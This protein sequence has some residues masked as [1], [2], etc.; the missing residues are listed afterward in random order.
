MESFRRELLNF[1]EDPT[2]RLSLLKNREHESLASCVYPESYLKRINELLEKNRCENEDWALNSIIKL[3]VRARINFSKESV[4]EN[5]SD[6][7][8][9]NKSMR[10]LCEAVVGY[11]LYLAELSEADLSG[12]LTLQTI[13]RLGDTM[14]RMNFLLV[15][16]KGAGKSLIGMAP[17]DELGLPCLFID[18]A[19]TDNLA[20]VGLSSQWSNSSEGI[21]AR[22]LLRES[23]FPL[24]VILDEDDKVG[25]INSVDLKDVISH[26]IDPLKTF[27]DEFLQVPLYQY[28]LSIF[29]LTAN[30]LN[31]LPD[32]L[33]SRTVVYNVSYV[34]PEVRLKIVLNK[35]T[36][37]INQLDIPSKIIDELFRDEDFRNRVIGIIETQNIDI[38][39]LKHIF[40]VSLMIYKYEYSTI[41]KEKR[42]NFRDIF[43]EQLKNLTIERQQKY[44]KGK[45]KIGFL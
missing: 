7:I 33:I 37:N 28:R 27:K 30:N 5:L 24:I 41:A 18:C 3:P 9:E 26:I 8:N 22:E 6:I 19:N 36:Q 45:N 35:I 43:L 16:D 15:G 14:P 29:I 25:F 40:Q 38:R 10:G 17:A 34:R 21:L 2:Y 11:L 32:Y 12:A 1:C 31:V 39:A 13:E 4:R 20:L 23:R 42:R 44:E